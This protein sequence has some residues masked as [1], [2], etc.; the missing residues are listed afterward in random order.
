MTVEVKK[1]TKLIPIDEVA[2]EIVPNISGRISRAT[3]YRLIQRG[4]LTKVN[5]GR[6][7]FVTS[8]SISAYIERLV[9]SSSGTLAR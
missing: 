2:K 6:R 8:D 9:A 3:I 4:E 1:P 7:G 5:I